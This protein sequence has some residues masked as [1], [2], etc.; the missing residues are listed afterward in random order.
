MR[1]EAMPMV[2]GRLR[3]GQL[4]RG[5]AAMGEVMPIVAESSGGD[6]LPGGLLRWEAMPIVAGKLRLGQPARGTA[7]MGGY[8]YRSKKARA[9]TSGSSWPS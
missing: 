2:A 8:A 3:L 7:A 9:I 5:T 6:S 1:W 4:V